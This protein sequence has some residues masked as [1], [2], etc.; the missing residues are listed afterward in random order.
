M[1]PKY[2]EYGSVSAILGGKPTPA[3]IAREAAAKP[4]PALPVVVGCVFVPWLLFTTTFWL[5]SFELRRDSEVVVN[6]LCYCLLLPVV[7]FA[8]MTYN[9]TRSGDPKPMAFL[10]LTSL[11]AWCAAF[12]AGDSNY[13][14]FMRPYYDINNLNVYPSVDA[15]KY[16]GAQLMDAGMIQFKA[17]TKLL[18]QKSIGFKNDE[19]YCA[20][21][22]VSN[23]TS[24]Q[25]TY[26]F[27]AVGINCCSGHTP[28]FH[29][30]EYTNPLA[31]W[32]LRLMDDSKRDMFRLAV[33]EA[34][35]TF[36]LNAPHPVFLYWLSDP[37][38]EVNAY[39]DDG[40]KFFL[41]YVFGCFSV[42]LFVVVFAAA[43][44]A[45]M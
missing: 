33:K 29:C 4:R 20:A 31:R 18:L 30:G 37:T 26:D 23:L 10:A 1:D 40:F 35:A 42:Q 27:W 7:A 12:L 36:N 6:F 44:F 19:V 34:E 22:I 5:R 8:V 11:L 13:N 39:Q 28:D 25:P 16:G 32:G 2:A 9:L 14:A 45:K 21:P 24:T 43:F 41:M 38:S 17:G 3:K 15:S